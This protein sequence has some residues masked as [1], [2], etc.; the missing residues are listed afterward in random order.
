MQEEYVGVLVLLTLAAL[1]SVFFSV[2]SWLLG[3]RKNTPYKLAPY[4]C[5][6]EPLGDTRE[7]F[8]IKFYLTAILFIMFDIEVVFL[9][10]WMTAFKDASTE[11]MM[12]SFIYFLTYMVT[13]I[14]GYA[15]AIRVGAIEWDEGTEAEK[16]RTSVEPVQ[17]AA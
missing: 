13:W 12:F 7:R 9:W 15:Y 2:I 1:V 17:G 4:E 14:L 6:V 3:P 5:G 10:S 11:F 16:S 8:P